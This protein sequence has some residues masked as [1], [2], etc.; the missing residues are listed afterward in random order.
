MEKDTK[1]DSSGGSERKNRGTPSKGGKAKFQKFGRRNSTSS[2]P[3]MD[4]KETAGGEIAVPPVTAKEG[5]GKFQKFRR[6][7][8]TSSI[9][10][11]Q[12]NDKAPRKKKGGEVEEI[13]LTPPQ[14]K[15]KPFKGPIPSPGPRKAKL[16]L[17]DDDLSGRSYLLN[18]DT[19]DF[20]TV[21]GDNT[22]RGDGDDSI[23]LT[24]DKESDES[25]VETKAKTSPKKSKK[26]TKKTTK[27]KKKDLPIEEF[28]V[29][30]DVFKTPKRRMKNKVAAVK[31]KTIS[32]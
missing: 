20:E 17:A 30:T 13:T 18:Y 27:K 14:P 15:K 26:K 4:D 16:I 21:N 8:S 1:Q 23:S 25:D 5:K 3:T 9:P 28:P 7:N 10:D 32:L 6:R 29:T 22:M 24:S 12:N 31:S 11:I 19:D 2:I